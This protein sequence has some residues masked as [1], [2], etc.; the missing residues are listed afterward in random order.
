MSCDS[1]TAVESAITSRENSESSMPALALGDAVAH[2]RHAARDLRRAAGRARR[3]LDQVGKAGVGLMGRQ[4]VVVGGDDREIGAVALAQR[5][6]VA[7]RAGGEAVGEIGAA[8]PLARPGR[9]AAAASIR[10]R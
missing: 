4:H 8:E 5:L 3:L 9:L 1:A 10:S 2:R 6:L 7:R